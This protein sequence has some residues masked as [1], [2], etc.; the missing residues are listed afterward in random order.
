MNWYHAKGPHIKNNFG[1]LSIIEFDIAYKNT[2]MAYAGK[3]FCWI[4]DDHLHAL[5]LET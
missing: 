5:D 3:F 4:M 1:K 2:L